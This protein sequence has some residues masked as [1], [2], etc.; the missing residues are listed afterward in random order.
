MDTLSEVDIGLREK[1]IPR[2]RE[3]HRTLPHEAL[4]ILQLNTTNFLIPFEDCK[5]ISVSYLVPVIADCV[6]VAYMK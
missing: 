3:I 5:R 1:N 4:L 6:K 2:H